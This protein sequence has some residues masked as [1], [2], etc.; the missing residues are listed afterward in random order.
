MNDAI[1][2]PG[3]KTT[4]LDGDDSNFDTIQARFNNL[5]RP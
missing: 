1:S 2:A 5:K 3:A 4:G